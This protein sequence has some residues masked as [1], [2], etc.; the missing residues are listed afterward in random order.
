MKKSKKFLTS[1]AIISM[2]LTTVPSHAFAENAASTRLAGTTAAQTA[3]AIA[4]QTGWTGT[5][6]LA[7]SASYG[8][9]DAL[10]AGPLSS[11][12]KAPIL[13][14]GPGNTL[15]P[16]TKAELTKLNVKTVYV[17]SGKAVISQ[18]VLDQLSA[19]GIKVVSIGGQDRAE[20]SVNIAKK[21]VGVTKV[22]VANGL[23]DA[24][25]IASIAS[26]ANEP[27]LITDK[28]S[29]PPSVAAF[30][31]ANPSI[32]STD[33]IG[34]TGVISDSVAAQFPHATR[35]AGATAYDTNNQVIQDFSSSLQFAN[36]YVANG[37]TGIDAL[38]GA[39]LAALTKSPIVL[40]DGTVPASAT[41]VHSK[42]AENAVV[43]ALGGAAVVSDAVRTGVLTGSVP[44]QVGPL[45][46]T[47]V[48]AVSASSIKV[49]FN[50]APA[51]TSKVTFSITNSGA[52]VTVTP[53]WNDTKTVAT[54]SGSANFPEGT[55]T[56]SVKNGESD[57]GS[58][59]VAITTQKI[60][61]IN[62]TAT[63]L[64]VTQATTG[65]GIGY[66]TFS[67]I[68]QYGNDITNSYLANNIQWQCGVGNITSPSHGVLKVTPNGQNLLTFSTVV[69]T[70]YDSTSGVSASATLPTSTAMGTLSSIT[71]NK[72]T[73]VNNT[74][75]TAADTSDT[76]YVDYTAN[77][78]S[79]N[80][81]ND[82]NLVKNGLI[83]TGVNS[84][85]L[86]VSSPYV[87]AKIVQDPNDSNK[88]AIQVTVTVDT[89]QT[90]MPVTITAMGWQGAPSG[91]QL[92][93]K[94]QQ[95]LYSFNLMAPSYNVASGE[96][97][98]I[99]FMAYDQN[100]KQLTK[101]DDIKDITTGLTSCT[102]VEN[103]D[104]T[105]SLFNTPIAVSGNQ[106]I[107]EILTAVTT[108]GKFSS[109]TL[110]VQ[111]TA[112]PKTL[113]LNTSV[114]LSTMQNG[115]EQFIDFGIN[116]GGLSVKD[117]YGRIY[118][119][120]GKATTSSALTIGGT[121]A[122]PKYCYQVIATTSGSISVTGT[123]IY[124][125]STYLTPNPIASGAKGIC[126]KAN[127]ANS[128]NPTGA[129]SGTITFKLINALD[130]H[131]GTVSDPHTIID[132]QSVD[133]SVLAD[134]DVKGYTI[135]PV[136]N[137]IYAVNDNS[138]LSDYD[139][140]YAAN[141]HVYGTTSSGSKIKLRGKPV[142]AVAVDSKDF[143]VVNNAASGPIAYDKVKV[144]AN[145]LD[146]S[147][148]SSSTNLTVTLN[149]ADGLVH[150][151]TTPIKSSTASPVTKM[152]VAAVG[153]YLPTNSLNDIGD[154]AKISANWLDKNKIMARFDS[155]GTVGTYGPTH[156]GYDN[157]ANLNT[158]GRAAVY[159][160]GVDQYG[161]KAIPLDSIRV[162][163]AVKADG[164][165]P[166]A[167]SM[168]LDG[169]IVTPPDVGDVIKLTAVSKNG[170]IKSIEIIV[171]PTDPTYMSIYT[172]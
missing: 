6:I 67:V 164:V 54:L 96:S 101:Y 69:L 170:M 150:A 77:D 49:Q 155:N 172:D 38:A 75:L 118:D 89:I 148:D 20:T 112:Q 162:V 79:G 94:K 15:D 26:A 117:Q 9:V 83:L 5:A 146:P 99:P 115:S 124:G 31:A 44:S 61:K 156:N 144:V 1:L 147:K 73:N 157:T 88:A 2:T 51:D 158:I 131:L 40:T 53:T 125:N 27:I 34:G 43:T 132:S 92:T 152:L 103:V 21:M 86:S 39:P 145:D 65:S 78:M 72:L 143:T 163:S 102:L 23:Q 32:T 109:I 97:K 37:K 36:V 82:Y 159:F 11:Y 119:M 98:M 138:T 19:M 55:Y 60:A 134:T 10:T 24:L 47:S 128:T 154:V 48:T 91:L 110:N 168:N 105:A 166:S 63:K 133:I 13:L 57:L 140:D 29:V 41:F 106:S 160:L 35:H 104:G 84:D 85:Q 22:A 33:I 46:V 130:G 107:P 111:P 141:P 3:T 80:P 90:D 56:V 120:I 167:F 93:L 129:G 149:G 121:V 71:L 123:D 165:T 18:A 28:N 136:P 139:I 151:L 113:T 126:I 142:I 114:L 135:D 4:D 161:T 62:I 64:A 16:D 30:L 95:S 100:G 137:P 17:T 153:T 7:S 116:Y 45:N 52:P 122:I 8:M 58:S 87:I 127:A 171:Q 42:L 108:T 81:T 70:G 76:W 14:T 66:A 50:T 59:T 25:S 74:P 12:L 169:T 68:D